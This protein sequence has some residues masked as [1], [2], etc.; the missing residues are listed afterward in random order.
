MNELRK[1]EFPFPQ[2]ME[3]RKSLINK[4]L[5][6]CERLKSVLNEDV[7]NHDLIVRF[8]ESG[9]SDFRLLYLKFI[10]LTSILGAASDPEGGTENFITRRKI[11]ADFSSNF[12]I[13]QYPDELDAASE[14]IMDYVTGSQDVLLSKDTD[15]LPITV[16][17]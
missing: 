12:R 8:H 14:V 2:G 13:Y 16:H 3:L 9:A 11:V 15:K 10:L 1:W 4:Q 17:Q 7:E 6:Y 5:E